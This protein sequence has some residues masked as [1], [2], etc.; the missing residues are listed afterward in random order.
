MLFGRSKANPKVRSDWFELEFDQKYKCWTLNY[1]GIEF[2]FSGTELAL[3]E[4]ATLD[5]YIEWVDARRDHINARV[6]D[7]VG[8]SPDVFID[9]SKAR[10]AQIE[11]ERP[12]R[13]AVMVLGDDTWGDMGYDLWIENGEIVNE[14]FSD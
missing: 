5:N 1:R 8:P 11:V 13:I 12:G 3:P 2:S 7:M 14:G 10:I 6:Q 4:R 9:T